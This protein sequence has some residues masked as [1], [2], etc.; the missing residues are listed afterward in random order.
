MS[1]AIALIAAA[2]LSY[3]GGDAIGGILG[4]FNLLGFGEKDSI[5]K[6]LPKAARGVYR[7]LKSRADHE[8][9]P[10]ARTELDEWLAKHTKPSPSGRS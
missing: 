5:L 4:R 3:I 10:E 1:G 7:A 9:T 8:G 6:R 2:G